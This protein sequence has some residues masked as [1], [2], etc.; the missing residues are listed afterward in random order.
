MAVFF[1][2]LT[3]IAVWV[4]IVWAARTLLLESWMNGVIVGTLGIVILFS[5]AVAAGHFRAL[6]VE[7]DSLFYL[8]E[9]LMFAT[10]PLVCAAVSTW[11]LVVE[12]PGLDLP[13]TFAL[14]YFAYLTVLGRPRTSSTPTAFLSSVRRDALVLSGEMITSMYCLP[15]VLCPLLHLA[16][17]HTLMGMQSMVEVLVG[18]L[19]A[20]V[21]P[22]LLMVTVAEGHADYHAVNTRIA[23]MSNLGYVRMGLSLLLVLLLQS[24]SLLDDVKDF[25]GLGEPTASWVLSGALVL[26]FVGLSLHT[27]PG[28]GSDSG[29]GSGSRARHDSKDVAD[30]SLLGSVCL[31]GAGFL[32]ALLIDADEGSY[33]LCIG[34][35]VAIA[36][37]YRADQ[38]SGGGGDAA[39]M[40]LLIGFAA[41]TVAN[42]GLGFTH[43]TLWFL[44]LDLDLPHGIGL[45]ALMRSPPS[46][47]E[48]EG[49][50]TGFGADQEL[51]WMGQLY[52]LVAPW[53]APDSDK[54]PV[55]SIRRLCVLSTIAAAVAVAAPAL[56]L[57]PVGMLSAL[58]RSC[59]NGAAA[60]AAKKTDTMLP[61]AGLG[62][63]GRGLGAQQIPSG[64]RG[65]VSSALGAVGSFIAESLFGATFST[66]SFF[67]AIL[68]LVVLEQVW[69]YRAVFFPFLLFSRCQHSNTWHQLTL[70]LTSHTHSH[71]THTR[72]TGRNMVWTKKTCTPATS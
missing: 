5:F 24:S 66:F 28:A 10:M 34:G 15:V 52:V 62:S 2:L 64:L 65:A 3:S 61:M 72:R 9:S 67:I 44:S 53:T 46:E 71:R 59:G 18:L 48:W 60:A 63:P 23:T 31:G 25:S 69:C 40:F 43:K 33:P 47:R 19:G 41:A 57:R 7:Y 68:E 20:V 22:G 8:M 14:C 50:D 51:D 38:A 36:E 70:T 6:R 13:A 49:I 37:Y 12:L 58:S 39:Y 21:L 11:F 17:H 45:A 29:N 42:I 1:M 56:V 55:M 30:F 27:K 32:G 4:S 16:T 26:L 54:P 35:A